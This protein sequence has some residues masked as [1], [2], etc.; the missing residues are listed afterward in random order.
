MIRQVNSATGFTSTLAGAPNAYAYVDGIGTAARFFFPRAV[1]GDGVNLYITDSYN[2]AIRRLVIANGVVT[3]FAGNG[4]P[5]SADGI[6]TNATFNYPS[7]IWGDGVNL[8]V[9]DSSN[10]SIRKINLATREVS[11]FA[12]L[13]D[14][15]GKIWGDRSNLYVTVG[16]YIVKVALSS[17]TQSIVAGG[18]Y[19]SDDGLDTNAG[20]SPSGIWGN[21][22][23]LYVTDGGGSIRK[24]VPA[25]LSAPTLS[26]IAPVSGA[27]NTTV[28]VTLKGTNFISG[29]TSVFVGG[30]LVTVSSVTV[31]GPDTLVAN[32][33][34]ASGATTG[35]RNVT[36]TTSAGTSPVPVTFTVN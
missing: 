10:L 22:S 2:H 29:G 3:T 15:P 8:Y 27:R 12:S 30:T 28:A 32:F 1:W 31:T 5:G 14:L 17:G 9:A 25:T 13:F 7:G 21:G 18:H 16:S 19:G 6:G 26:S 11:T 35:A 33:T 24:I 34:I 23:E 20:M 4:T 36:V